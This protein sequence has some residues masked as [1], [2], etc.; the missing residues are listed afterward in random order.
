MDQELQINDFIFCVAHFA[1][2]FVVD[3]KNLKKSK[4]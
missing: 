3:K 1:Y 4:R 2:C